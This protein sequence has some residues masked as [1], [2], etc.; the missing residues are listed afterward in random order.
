MKWRF[1]ALTSTPYLQLL[2]PSLK[3]KITGWM[4]STIQKCWKHPPKSALALQLS[5]NMPIKVAL[6]SPVILAE[7]NIM[8]L[9]VKGKKRFFSVRAH[10]NTCWLAR[11]I[12]LW[13]T[14]PWHFS[15][16]F[17]RWFIILASNV[18][19]RLADR[20]KILATSSPTHVSFSQNRW[21]HV[22][23][24]TKVIKTTCFTWRET[25]LAT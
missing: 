17:K 23:Q 25:E 11:L 20:R 16:V 12:P 6:R 22:L 10:K 9:W 21:P 19:S 2:S 18:Q 3:L 14:Q 1:V 8:G 15:L 7:D 13:Q 24:D 4:P 5:C